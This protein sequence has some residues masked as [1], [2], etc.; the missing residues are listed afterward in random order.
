[1]HAVARSPAARAARPCS[2]SCSAA[3]LAGWA[4][5][6]RLTKSSTKR[7]PLDVIGRTIS[8]LTFS[9]ELP[10]FTILT[11]PSSTSAETTVKYSGAGQLFHRRTV[12]WTTET[13]RCR[14]LGRR[15]EIAGVR[16]TNVAALQRIAPQCCAS[17][18]RGR[19]I[20]PHVDARDARI[21]CP[22]RGLSERHEGEHPIIVLHLL[23]PP[24]PTRQ[25]RW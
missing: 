8:L 19:D 2:K 1:M 7:T 6:A 3:A 16:W 9:R 21:T 22:K 12:A 17:C 18:L 13:V 14:A 4:Y 10:A 23:R 20:V 15:A 5:V 24:S 11:K 25:A